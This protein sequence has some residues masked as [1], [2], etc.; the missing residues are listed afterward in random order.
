MFGMIK[1]LGLLL[2]AFVQLLDPDRNALKDA[3]PQIKYITSVFLACFW[4]VAFSLYFG[5][6]STLGYNVI[7]HFAVVSMAFV[8]WAVFRHFRRTYTLRNDYDLL[9]DPARTPKCY[10][11]TDTER[12]QAA[13]KLAN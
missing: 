11:L 1:F 10:E 13:A 4:A 12:A 3:P 8:T 7:G 2:R 5:E 9:R 6:L